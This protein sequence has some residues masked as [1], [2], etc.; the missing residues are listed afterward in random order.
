MVWPGAGLAVLLSLAAGAG[1]YAL[2]ISLEGRPEE[3]FEGL[4]ML[5]AAGVLT[6]MIFRMNRQGRTIQ[7]ELERDVRTPSAGGGRCATWL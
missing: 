7:E 4:A 1:L 3:V 5:F 2:G 6:W